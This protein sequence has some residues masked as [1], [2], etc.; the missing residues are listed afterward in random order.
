MLNQPTSSPMITRMLGFF[1]CAMVC[2]DDASPRTMTTN[3]IVRVGL[4][5]RYIL[6][7]LS[8][9]SEGNDAAESSSELSRNIRIREILP[10]RL[11]T[12]NCQKYPYGYSARDKRARRES[13][14]RQSFE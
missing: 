2:G 8:F 9:S 10:E 5:N 1:S 3:A 6:M 12:C 4:L 7:S 13:P 14:Q 11:P